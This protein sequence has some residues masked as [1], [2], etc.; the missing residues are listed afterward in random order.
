VPQTRD[1][2]KGYEVSQKNC[3]R[4]LQNVN[5]ANKKIQRKGG[6]NRD[7]GRCPSLGAITRKPVTELGRLGEKKTLREQEDRKIYLSITQGVT[8][9]GE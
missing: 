7:G 9:R 3:N 1:E 2:R 4:N 6:G 8:K 5:G